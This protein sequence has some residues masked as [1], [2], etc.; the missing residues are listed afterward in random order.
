MIVE[1]IRHRIAEDEARKLDN[2]NFVVNG[3]FKATAR[4]PSHSTMPRGG[5]PCG[6][7]LMTVSSPA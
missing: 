1:Y 4:W 7:S 5:C 3:R 6:Y 2:T